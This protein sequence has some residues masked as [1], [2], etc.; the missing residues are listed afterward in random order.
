[1]QVTD[2]EPTLE[3]LSHLSGDEVAMPCGSNVRLFLSHLSGD[4]DYKLHSA[5]CQHFLSHL[6][7]D[8]VTL[9]LQAPA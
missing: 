2:Y 8:E 7:G 9:E 3:F 1:M 4:E 5:T 6:S